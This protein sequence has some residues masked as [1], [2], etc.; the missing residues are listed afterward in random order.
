[1]TLSITT[2]YSVNDVVVVDRGSDVSIGKIVA[3]RMMV[4]TNVG[5]SYQYEVRFH[6]KHA[7]SLVL[8]DKIIDTYVHEARDN[9]DRLWKEWAE[10]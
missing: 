4:T 2:K 1:M 3:I 5:V 7:S 6:P 8:E 9:F 10:S